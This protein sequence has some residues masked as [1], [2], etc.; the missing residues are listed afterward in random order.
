MASFTPYSEQ[1]ALHTD[2]KYRSAIL[3]QPANLRKALAD[4]QA[5]ASKT[6]VGIAHGIPSVFVT[7]LIA[8]RKPDFVW[9]DV[10]HGVFNRLELHDAVHAAQHHSEG[11]SMVVVRVPKHDEISL[12]TA[13]DAGA[14]GIIIPHCESAEEV[15]AFK[16]ET[17]FR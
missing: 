17:F 7:K 4:A 15:E 8:S 10:E 5:D 9:I 1:Q 11:H 2:A 13:L 16:K 6:L 14:A 3:T 12:T